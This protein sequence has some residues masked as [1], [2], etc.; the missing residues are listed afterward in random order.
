MKRRVKVTFLPKAGKGMDT[1][2]SG[3]EVRMKPG[4][5]F[6]ATQ[7]NWPV[8]AGEFSKP[9][10]AV[11]RTLKPVNRED[12]NLEAEVGETAVT[13]LNGD[14][15][16]EHYKIGGKRHSAG[17]TPLYLPDNSFIFSR[18]R[19]MKIKDPILLAQFG[20]PPLKGGYTPADIAKKYD[21]NK[22]RKILGDPDTDD[23]QRKSA[24]SMIANY[25]LK[26]G[27]L[28]IIQ[29]SIKGFPNGIPAIAMPYLEATGIDP[30]DLMGGGKQQDEN[31]QTGPPEETEQEPQD[32]EQQNIPELPEPDQA[33]Y[34]MN[35]M[36]QL[37]KR[38]LGGAFAKFATGGDTNKRRVKVTYPSLSKFAVGGQA[39][40]KDAFFSAVLK[41]LNAPV[42]AENLEVLKTWSKYEEGDYGKS[43]FNH[44]NTTQKAAGT[45]DF[46]SAGVKNY[47]DFETGVKATIQTLSNK[48]YPDILN[49]LKENKGLKWFKKN[50]KITNQLR[51]WGTE[52]FANQL[53]GGTAIKTVPGTPVTTAQPSTKDY[54]ADFT[55]LVA[56]V[57]DPKVQ[58][59]IYDN[60]KKHIVDVK[61]PAIKKELELKSK[62]AVISDFLN[63]QKQNYALKASGVDLT[64]DEWK[65]TS[66]PEL[67][68]QKY[69]KAAGLDP[70]DAST[71]ISGQAA[72]A[73]FVDAS[74]D[75]ATKSS[76][77]WV[78]PK[79]I[80]VAD[81]KY[82][83]SSAQ[84]SA[85][86]GI[87]GNTTAGQIAEI[88]NPP[89]ATE[90]AKF[91][92]LGEEAT[93]PPAKYWQQDIIK[94]MNAVG[95]WAGAKEYMPWQA[96]PATYLPENTVYSPER[97]LAAGE[98]SSN[99]LAK[100]MAAFTGAQGLSSR[101]SSIQGQQAKNAADV[102]GRY[103]NLN[104]GAADQ[105]EAQKTSILNQA[106]QQRAA[107]ATQLYDKVT[108]ANQQMDNTKGI[109][110][111]QAV[112][113]LAQAETNKANT[114][115]LN[116]LNPQYAVD[117]SRAGK[118]YFTHGQDISPEQAPDDDIMK[119][120][121]QY[122]SDY[123]SF[124]PTE[125]LD[126]AKLKYGKGS[127]G[128]PDK[129]AEFLAQ[130]GYQQ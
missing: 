28:A 126:A 98:E 69:I 19:S 60:Y 76:F 106:A 83:T 49:A 81:E 45:T 84:V 120:A 72:Y 74:N 129:L 3:L 36:A 50:K 41:G 93:V 107:L 22:F 62:S 39:D 64:T 2:S 1:R 47:P 119:T 116:S 21:I 78:K 65:N 9:D 82:L 86:D 38:K 68:Y 111:D 56:K 88:Y 89:A 7:L 101:A 51:T 12:A 57:A 5:G 23:L 32:Q 42:T 53:D 79:Q 43:K 96:T 52:N 117:P 114:Y 25:N 87:Y 63:M 103:A 75:K 31:E 37:Q 24:E 13:D 29:E 112:E 128:N 124:S 121:Q 109:L 130:A 97:E 58:D 48:Y 17:G 59:A 27:K 71:I 26:L 16:P 30:A 95:N 6:N 54:N 44:L 104:V 85:P 40:N 8:M 4:L 46:N 33:K 34:G 14:G 15:I 20:M 127:S 94:G 105:Y 122:L 108:V 92:H 110:K 100:A 113:L 73:G 11:N 77:T 80:G 102:L 118:V 18:D 99:A 90:G 55:K 10:T 61:D 66:H 67:A 70:M 115:N 35:I 91:K 125:A 123:P